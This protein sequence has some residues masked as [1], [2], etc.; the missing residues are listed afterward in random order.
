[1]SQTIDAF[2][3]ATLYCFECD[4]VT[5]KTRIPRLTAVHEDGLNVYF[6]CRPHDLYTPRLENA[7]DA[8]RE[9]GC[10]RRNYIVMFAVLE[11]C[12]EQVQNYA[13]RIYVLKLY[14]HYCLATC[15]FNEIDVF[16]LL[17]FYFTACWYIEYKCIH[18]LLLKLML[19]S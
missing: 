17:L 14:F 1:V 16:T 8:T 7:L 11:L 10:F 6:K 5:F 9:P 2:S 3:K 4:D 19:L 15:K 18:C 12:I 13:V